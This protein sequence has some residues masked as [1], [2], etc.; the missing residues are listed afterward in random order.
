V[1]YVKDLTLAHVRR[2]GWLF[3]DEL[4]WVRKGVPGGWP[5]RFKAFKAGWEFNIWTYFNPQK[6]TR[7]VQTRPVPAPFAA[8]RR[9]ARGVRRREPSP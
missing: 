1:L 9:R 6:E 7:P 2:W 8:F 3:V 5:N 4:A